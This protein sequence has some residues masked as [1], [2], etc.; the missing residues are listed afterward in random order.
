MKN[1]FTLIMMMIVTTVMFSQ[2]TLSNEIN[3]TDYSVI[4]TAT[5][6]GDTAVYCENVGV[7]LKFVSDFGFEGQNTFDLDSDDVVST[8][9]L[10]LMLS[11]YGR[12]SELPDFNSLVING[13]FS[14]GITFFEPTPEIIVSFMERT[15]WDEIE[16]TSDS[17][18]DV[19]TFE[20]T[21]IGTDKIVTKFI[22][23]KK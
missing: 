7:L 12:A 14:G 13:T 18:F 4:K 22:A 1:F 11:G 21:V 3:Q 2:N 17:D 19:E 8:S 20:L 5:A 15:M 6:D 16:T 9:D 23:I 10:S